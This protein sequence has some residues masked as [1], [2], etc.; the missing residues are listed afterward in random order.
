MI[1]YCTFLLSITSQREQEKCFACYFR[2]IFLR[3]DS[4]DVVKQFNYKR[5]GS[6]SN[7]ER[8]VILWGLYYEIDSIWLKITGTAHKNRNMR[9]HTNLAWMLGPN[10]SAISDEIIMRAFWK[11]FEPF[12]PL[13]EH[14]LWHILPNLFRQ[15]ENYSPILCRLDQNSTVYYL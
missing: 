9:L 14:V 4:W 7:F 15:N 6:E 10:F 5:N 12:E 11:P 1:E 8:F 2:D 3:D 13:R